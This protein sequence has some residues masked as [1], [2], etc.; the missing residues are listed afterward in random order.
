MGIIPRNLG[1]LLKREIES[2]RWQA[3]GRAE[4]GY[5]ARA[6]NGSHCRISCSKH[7][8]PQQDFSRLRSSLRLL[9]IL[10]SLLALVSIVSECFLLL[11]ISL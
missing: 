10:G 4:R 5:F 6:L 3:M 8:P 1:S 11:N 7:S 9:S 2:L